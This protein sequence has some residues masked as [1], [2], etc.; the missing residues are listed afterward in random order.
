[1]RES[2]TYIFV[3]EESAVESRRNSNE[4]QCFPIP[5]WANNNKHNKNII[6]IN[7]IFFVGLTVYFS[8]GL[9]IS[10][11]FGVITVSQGAMYFFVLFC[12][13]PIL[14]PAVYFMRN[15][16]HLIS[17]LQDHNFMSS[18]GT[19]HLAIP[20]VKMYKIVTDFARQYFCPH[21]SAPARVRARKCVFTLSVCCLVCVSIDFFACNTFNISFIFTNCDV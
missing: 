7:G 20:G 14:L 15:P 17:V 2:S 16:K 19:P 8:M 11:R 12:C 18:A 3:T 4:P 21:I 13:I 6:N 5:G 10:T 9:A 1:M